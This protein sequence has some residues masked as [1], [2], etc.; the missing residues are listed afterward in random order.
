MARIPQQIY[1]KTPKRLP[2]ELKWS[3][4]GLDFNPALLQYIHI[5]HHASITF[6]VEDFYV[7]AWV[8]LNLGFATST[9]VSKTKYGVDGWYIQI[10]NTGQINFVQMEP[11]A[12][13]TNT[14]AGAV[15]GGTW[16]HLFLGR[17]S[18]TGYLYVNGVQRAN[19][20]PALG[21]IITNTRNMNIARY[22]DLGIEYFDGN[23]DE[24]EIVPT[25]ITRELANLSFYRGY[26]RRGTDSRL[27]LRMEDRV[28]LTAVDDSGYGND[29]ALLPIIS[30]PTWIDVQKYQLLSEAGV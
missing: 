2:E 18:G 23:I 5:P 14:P 12:K 11:A 10:K 3:N 28:G 20:Q 9:L 30:P 21:N 22:E 1:R 29:G 27:L 26:A 25:G 4:Y 15:I 17:N 13:V 8:R 7:E 6:T 24:F 16:H 19:V